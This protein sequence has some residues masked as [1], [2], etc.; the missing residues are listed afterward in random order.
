M[1]SQWPST[2]ISH[3]TAPFAASLSLCVLTIGFT[4]QNSP[5]RSFGLIP[6]LGCVF[7]A[8]RAV[9]TTQDDTH[10]FSTSFLMGSTSSMVLQYLDS[11]LLSRWT[12]EA[13]GPTSGLGGQTALR[14]PRDAGHLLGRKSRSGSIVDRMVFKFEE[15]LHARSAGTPWEVKHVPKFLADGPDMVPMRRAYLSRTMTHYLLSLSVVDVISY[16]GRDASM[17]STTFAPNRVPLVTSMPR[18]PCHG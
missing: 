3:P 4:S 12:Y 6:E 13:R 8:W 11:V 14:T 5:L 10:Q 16:M 17:N 1:F 2:A 7:L 18:K 15:T 9:R